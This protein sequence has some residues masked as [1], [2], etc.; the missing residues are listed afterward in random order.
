MANRGGNLKNIIT[1]RRLLRR[2]GGLHVARQTPSVTV[3]LQVGKFSTCL[4]IEIKLNS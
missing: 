4:E 1:R 2:R 3:A